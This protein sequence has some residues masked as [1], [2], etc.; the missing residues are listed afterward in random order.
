MLHDY[1]GK[2]GL[3]DKE[4]AIYVVLAELGVQP[5]SVVA[6]R[7][8]LDRVTTY[9]H[10]KKLGERGFVKVYVRDGIQYFGIESFE[11]LYGFL[12][13]RVEH[14]SEL[15]KLY[16][17]AANVLRSL[18]GSEDLVP[19]LQLFEGESGMRALLR[20]ILF[21]LQQGGLRQVRMLTANVFEEWTADASLEKIVRGFF[22]ELQQ[23]G[24]ALDH[25]EVTGGMV[26]ER[27]RHKIHGNSPITGVTVVRGTTGIF[28]VGHAVY[29]ACYRGN[30][31]GLKMQHAEISQ[32]FH[33][34]FDLVGRGTPQ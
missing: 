10:L 9:K 28:V 32:I 30:Q 26:P 25:F 6:R 11:N 23:R 29:L 2:L 18:R 27:L 12:Q 24:I 4:R 1:L 19:R 17:T 16:P 13:E 33:F 8:N 21:T 3:T 20:D 7:C 15:A 5:A 34:L 14:F 22:T 31:I